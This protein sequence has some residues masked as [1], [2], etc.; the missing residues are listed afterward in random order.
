LK[1]RIEIKAVHLPDDI[2]LAQALNYLKV[3]DLRVGLLLNFGGMLS[4]S[5]FLATPLFLLSRFFTLER[6]NT[7]A[8]APC[9]ARVSR[10]RWSRFWILMRVSMTVRVCDSLDFSCIGAIITFNFINIRSA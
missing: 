2:H 3:F 8:V 5:S 6:S 4:L 1:W 10:F 9:L 7:L